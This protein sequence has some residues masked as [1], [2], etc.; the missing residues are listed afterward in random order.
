MDMTDKKTFYKL[1]AETLASYGKNL[2]DPGPLL[3]AWWNDLKAFPLPAVAMAFAQHK[4]EEGAFPPIPAGITKRCKTLDGRPG[5]EEAW[6]MLPFDAETSA[7]WTDE[8][9]GAWGVADPLIASGDR[10]GGRMTFKQAYNRLVKQARDAAVPVRWS[11]TQGS[12]RNGRQAALIDAVRNQRISMA[13]A[14]ALLPPD[15]AQ[16][17]LMSLGVKKHPLLA[18]PDATGQKKLAALMLSMKGGVV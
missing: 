8:M 17:M 11:L 2:P 13:D 12:D 10:I 5:D 7:V 18:A 9:A 14:V 15:D 1:L 3:D 6:A 4:D 16:G